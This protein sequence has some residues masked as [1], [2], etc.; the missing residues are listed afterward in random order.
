MLKRLAFFVCLT[1]T[2][3]LLLI[4]MRGAREVR[5]PEE[6]EASHA[7]EAIRFRA[8]QR[9]TPGKVMRPD[10]LWRA[11]LQ[12]DAMTP[13]E[14]RMSPGVTWTWL[15]PG[16]IGGRIRS[17]L[18]DPDNVNHILVGA[19]SGGIWNT[20]DGGTNWAPVDDF[21]ASLCVNSMARH[22]SFH[23]ILY[24]GTGEGVTSYDEFNCPQGGGIFKSTNGGT[25]WTLL[26]S[27][28]SGSPDD[29]RFMY[30]NRV[31]VNSAGSVFASTN[32]SVFK[33]DNGGA[34]WDE[35]LDA[36]SHQVLVHPTD[37]NKLLVEA[38]SFVGNVVKWSDDG[39]Q[40]LT[41]A[42]WP[43]DLPTPGEGRIELAQCR[44]NPLIVYASVHN[45]DT[46]PG[47]TRGLFRSDD[48]G[49]SF[50]LVNNA[51]PLLGQQGFYANA[52]WV[53]PVN[54]DVVI[55][56]GLDLYRSLDAGNT[57][58]KISDWKL[59]PSSA[60]ADHH[61]IVESADY[62][63]VDKTNVFFGNDGGIYRA[64]PR[65]V[66]VSV[67]W[68]YLNNKLGI[69]QF[70]G[71]AVS[72]AG[73]IY[74][75]AQ[76]NG[77]LKSGSTTEDWTRVPNTGD[78]GFTQCDP[79][80]AN[81]VYGE[82][83]HGAAW[84]S[85]D[86]G[87]SIEDILGGLPVEADRS[88]Q[89]NFISPLVLDPHDRKR[90]YLGGTRLW[91]CD[92]T[93]A[94]P[95]WLAVKKPTADKVHISTISVHPSNPDTLMV[96]DNSG[97]IFRSLN[98]TAAAGSLTWKQL[99]AGV[100]PK[101]YCSSIVCVGPLDV[102]ATFMG[103][104]KANVW[105]S[106]D[107]GTTWKSI[108][109]GL[110]EVSVSS[111][112][113][114]WGNHLIVGTDIGVF[115]RHD[116]TLPWTAAKDGLA[117]VPV[118]QL[119]WDTGNSLVA[120]TYGRG[121]YRASIPKT[122]ELVNLT[123]PDGD[124]PADIAGNEN[125][126]PSMSADGRYIAFTSQPPYPGVAQVYVYD[127]VL[128]SVTL[129][130][131]SSTGEPAN[132]GVTMG[133]LFGICRPIISSNGRFVVYGSSSTNLDPADAENQNDIYIHDRTTGI[134]RVASMRANGG[135]RYRKPAQPCGVTPDGKFVL[136]AGGYYFYP[137]DRQLGAD[138]GLYLK[139]METGHIQWLT[140][141]P[142]ANSAAHGRARDGSMS[143]NAQRIVFAAYGGYVSGD[144]TGLGSGFGVYTTT[145]SGGAFTFL[146]SGI[147]NDSGWCD[148]D[149]LRG[150]SMD[151][152]IS[153]DGSKV[154][155]TS[156][157]GS[158]DFPDPEYHYPN[159]FVAP[160]PAGP[161]TLL[162]E[163][164]KGSPK[165]RY[166]SGV[167]SYDGRFI[168]YTALPNDPSGLGRAALMLRDQKTGTVTN[169][170][171]TTFKPE[172]NYAPNGYAVSRDGNT[173]VFATTD[174]LLANDPDYISDIYVKR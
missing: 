86:A 167:P 109:V 122:G 53:D 38:D 130:S 150:S 55:V 146:T 134:T 131:K 74:G 87:A 115:D 5:E 129:V 69:T 97:R 124:M 1:I 158:A 42:A 82:Y 79:S 89:F 153:A 151:V 30:V 149:F 73:V 62:N 91:R 45:A 23:N 49:K 121:I 154:V 81:L 48:A 17:I 26:P 16:N 46:N 128:R 161:S 114:A 4:N 83:V 88:D 43:G 20:L 174:K 65:T 152:K 14:R 159:V 133:V 50:R 32:E 112:A 13:S 71:A 59:V 21:M 172:P 61:V 85:K 18:T 137:D 127:L 93:E 126:Y 99:G 44:S 63:G 144:Y 39:G 160:Y 157:R 171:S 84:R 57:F 56:G 135:P 7:A 35:I 66:Q 8:S 107:G 80:D 169:V 117:N 116:E 165:D 31:Q 119:F 163:V 78:G 11:K 29:T 132:S 34:T 33:S 10:A 15:G 54:P 19:V 104:E 77:E 173:V 138:D 142:A 60:H 37:A 162:P 111:I 36:K 103:Y 123:G 143:D 118:D 2:G 95:T 72:P 156:V 41:N 102:Y 3:G 28:V 100:L 9:I 166:Y 67:G 58:T 155:Y 170:S 141:A 12:R 136:F 125:L 96:G 108:G 139:N 98:A 25:T 27:T 94:N 113:V 168:L 76:D 106:E 47:G 145:K 70:Y 52:L 40:T 64:A 110:P 24:A 51:A 6:N 147:R 92:P 105:K 75:G 22:P 120:V 90:L 148:G 140:E 101:R 164:P 68:V